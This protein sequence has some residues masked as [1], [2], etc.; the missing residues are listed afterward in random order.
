MNSSITLAS[1]ANLVTVSTVAHCNAMIIRRAR[2]GDIHQDMDE[3]SHSMSMLAWYL[4]DRY[5]CLRKDL[6]DHPVKKGFR[7]LEHGSR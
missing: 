4:F 2:I 1:P 7:D 6:K 5:G 3:V